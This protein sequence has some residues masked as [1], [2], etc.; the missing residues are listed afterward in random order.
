MAK[1]AVIRVRGGI[2]LTNDLKD[3][4]KMLRLLKKNSCVV[5]E[6]TPCNLGM[7]KK[8]KDY[9]TWG[10]L[11]PE[12]EQMLKKRDKGKK[13]YA[14]NSPR[15]GFGRKGIKVAFKNKGALGDREEKIN[16]LLMRMI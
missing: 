14:L 3:T 1:I 6:D 7:V 11:S 8:I 10:K 16:D 9:V 15:K 12:V 5:I 4:F 13:Y 2:N